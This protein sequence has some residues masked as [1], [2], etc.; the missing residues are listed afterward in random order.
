MEVDSVAVQVA[1]ADDSPDMDVQMQM[2]SGQC[3]VAMDSGRESAEM[4]AEEQ[5]VTP[6]LKSVSLEAEMETEMETEQPTVTSSEVQR[7]WTKTNPETGMTDDRLH[8]KDTLEMMRQL[9]EA[10]EE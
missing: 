5:S 8:R 3:A 1:V 10:K 6:K 4:K 9:P 7:S 2:S